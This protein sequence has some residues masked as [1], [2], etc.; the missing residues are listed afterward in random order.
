MYNAE[1][2]DYGLSIF[3][4]SEKW[5]QAFYDNMTKALMYKLVIK[6]CV[7]LLKEWPAEEQLIWYDPSPDAVESSFEIT[8]DMQVVLDRTCGVLK[9]MF[10]NRWPRLHV[11]P[12]QDPV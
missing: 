11:V 8:E 12:G 1:N 6:R 10:K 2:N 7:N 9:D 3:R 4:A 5:T